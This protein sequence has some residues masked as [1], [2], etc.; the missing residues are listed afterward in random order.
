MQGPKTAREISFTQ[1]FGRD[2]HEAR[3]ACRRYT[4]YGEKRDLEKAWEIYYGV[5]RT[6]I[7]VKH[8]PLTPFI[9][10]RCSR[11]LRSSFRS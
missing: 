2:L 5:S 10:R 6:N 7:H 8:S 9:S 3:E 4:I 1:M 11:R